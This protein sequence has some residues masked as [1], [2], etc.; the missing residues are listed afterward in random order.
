MLHFDASSIMDFYPR[1][2]MKFPG[3]GN[4]TIFRT[5]EWVGTGMDRGCLCVVPVEE[6]TERE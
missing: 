1:L 6:T 5:Y 3:L 4:L 2:R